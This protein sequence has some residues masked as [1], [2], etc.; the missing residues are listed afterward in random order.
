MRDP[1]SFFEK[2]MRKIVIAPD[3]FKG[4]LSALE[5]AAHLAGGVKSA[6]PEVELRVLPLADGGEGTLEAVE[7]AR[8]GR[9]VRVRAC[10]PMGG[11]LEADILLLEGGRA[12]VEMARAAGLPLVAK[13]RRDPMAASTFGVGEMI[14]RAFE[15]GAT[16]VLVGSGGSATVDGGTGA[17]RALGVRFLDAT[18]KPVPEGGGG[19]ARIARAVVPDVLE[20]ILS[21]VRFRVLCDVDNPL[22]GP[23]GAARTFGPQ[24]GADPAMVEALEAGLSRFADAAREATGED[25]KDRAGAGS[26]GGFAA[27]LAA[28][29][30]AELVSGSLEILRMVGFGDAVKGAALVVTGEGRIDGQSV[31][32]KAVGAVA[33]ACGEAGVP[34]V[35]VAGRLGAGWTRVLTMGVH[36]VHPCFPPDAPDDP[37]LYARTPFRLAEIGRRLGLGLRG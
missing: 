20:S 25:V 17:L 3:P 15:S 7:R 18:G 11:P 37:A 35:A 14:L 4:S 31:S 27:G 9:R 22:L 26:A 33:A 2:T 1:G 8:G 21:T 6:L 32:G 34:C 5:V 30:K 24:K 16:E 23:E 10:G 29:L 36:A 12:V 28:F 19:L 13:D